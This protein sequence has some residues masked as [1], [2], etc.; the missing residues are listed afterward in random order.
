MGW[1]VNVTPR[2]LD[3]REDP[4]PIVQKAGWAP[5]P[6]WTGEENLASTVIR[7]PDLPVQSL[8]RLSYTGPA[9]QIILVSFAPRLPNN[10]NRLY[11]PIER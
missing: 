3:S 5:G 10:K 1:V 7:S 8:Y 11:A 6:V 4:V 9:L 2:P